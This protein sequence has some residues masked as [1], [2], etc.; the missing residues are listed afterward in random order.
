MVANVFLIIIPNQRKVVAQV[1]AG[2]TPDPALGKQAKQRSVH[3]NY[4]TLPVLLIM[5][6]NHYPMIVSSPLNWLWLAALGIVGWTIRH[7]FNLKNSGQL[8]LEVLAYGALGFVTVAVLNES[9]K[10]KPPESVPVPAFTEV[11]AIVDRNCVAC[12]AATPTHRGVPTAP[13]GAMFDTDAGLQKHAAKIYDRAV[14]T[15]SMPQGDETHMTD[16]ERAKLGAWIKAG[17]KVGS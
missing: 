5:L 11:R 3:N 7:F 14:A 13:N 10:P 8:R 6:S 9:V 17:A 4:M 15:H 1:L 16:L 2:E 12:H